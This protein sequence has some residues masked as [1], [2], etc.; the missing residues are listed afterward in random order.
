MGHKKNGNFNSSS[1]VAIVNT[2]WFHFYPTKML[3]LKNLQFR[4]FSGLNTEKYRPEKTPYLA[5]LHAVMQISL[6][7]IFAGS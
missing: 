5:F 7:R 6:L 3:V 1:K 4:V 2:V